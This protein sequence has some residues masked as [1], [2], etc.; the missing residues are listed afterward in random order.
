ML[1]LPR[2]C[3]CGCDPSAGRRVAGDRHVKIERFRLDRELKSLRQNTDDRVLAPV[4]F[5][6]RPSTFWSP[7][8]RFFHVS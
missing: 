8:N 5:D 4:E 7:P 1:W 6:V 3:V 2:C